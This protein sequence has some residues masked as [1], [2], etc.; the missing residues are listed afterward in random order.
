MA[1]TLG[2]VTLA[3]TATAGVAATSTS[4]LA[5]TLGPVTL[6]STGSSGAAGAA[7]G[8]LAATLGTVTLSSTAS[9]VQ[10]AENFGSLSAT[11]GSVTLASA[12]TAAA[13][14]S[15]TSTLAAT[16]GV[17]ALAS[18]ADSDGVL[19]DAA[20]TLA[21]TLGAATV[22]S[23]ARIPAEPIRDRDIFKVIVD[24][25]R[26]TGE[27]TG[28]VYPYAFPNDSRVSSGEGPAA[29]ITPT[30]WMQK[31]DGSDR[32]AF[33]KVSY[34]LTVYSW[35]DDPEEAYQALDRLQAIVMNELQG[36]DLDDLALPE[37]SSISEG[38]Y[39]SARH[40]EWSMEIPGSFAY[41][42]E[43]SAGLSDSL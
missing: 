16:L 14:T 10:A 31:P 37:H 6:A 35:H 33:R 2:S 11:L 12:G 22:I 32:V 18:V 25:L 39:V 27:F 43:N 13:P 36:S 15:A 29:V 21:V 38:R 40:P 1:A 41:W 5:V 20:A 24:A 4:T 34:S 26:A 19:G 8:T 3:S 28:G 9:P 42:W 30:K 17:V 7:A 23:T